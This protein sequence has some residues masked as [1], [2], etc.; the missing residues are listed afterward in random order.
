MRPA[1]EPTDADLVALR[2]LRAGLGLPA[3][4]T[5]AVVFAEALFVGALFAAAT[6]DALVF[7]AFLVAR[8]AVVLAVAALAV[9]VLAADLRDVAVF[10]ADFATDFVG[11][12]RCLAAVLR[13]GLAAA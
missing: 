4:A 7:E 3:D 11:A 1:A 5:D 6:F 10:A 9:V 8:A 12:M 2:A 13:A